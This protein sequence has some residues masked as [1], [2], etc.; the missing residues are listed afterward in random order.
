VIGD[1]RPDLAVLL[2]AAPAAPAAPVDGESAGEAA[3]A[4]ATFDPGPGPPGMGPPIFVLGAGSGERLRCL[5]AGRLAGVT[6]PVV[7]VEPC[8][9]RLRT[10]LDQPG[11][12]AVLDD[13]R[14][15][16]AV[17]GDLIGACGAAF[18][19]DP[20]FWF[21]NATFAAGDPAASRELAGGAAGGPWQRFIADVQQ[22]AR[23]TTA[24]LESMRAAFTDHRRRRPPLAALPP[25]TARI[26][27]VTDV[28]TSA[29][30][31]IYRDLFAAATGRGHEVTL[32]E[33]DYRSDPFRIHRRARAFLAAQPD[34]LVSLVQSRWQ[35]FGAL[36]DDVPAAV[37]YSSDPERY[38]LDAARFGPLDHVFVADPAWVA[39]LGRRGVRTAVL[40]L[41]TA[42][43]AASE[44]TPA[45][46]DACDAVMVCNLT[47]PESIAP[48][49]DAADVERLTALGI[50]LAAGGATSDALV[51]ASPLASREGPDRRLARA[52]E[53]AGTRHL[54]VQAA[55]RLAEA[56]LDLR[57]YGNDDWRAALAGTAASGAYRRSLDYRREVP[58]A[59]AGARVVVNVGSL[60][61]PEALNMR[62]FDAPAVGGCLVTDDRAQIGTVF[63]PGREIVVYRH[64]DELADIV[65]GL[66]DDPSRRDAIAEAGRAR[67]LRDHTYDRRWD[68]IIR[69]CTG[70]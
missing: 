24:D 27:G 18:D 64:L 41:A 8:P 4:A 67:V 33:E 63:A 13:R 40:P 30:Q 36:A 45:E 46:G 9:G 60:S 55:V 65:R 53:V 61:A 12:G 57:V 54:R 25:G 28:S 20:A 35:A 39:T 3:R 48:D 23:S 34:L 49:L 17:G 70:G 42:M 31:F 66:I 16:F 29:L 52:V 22:H 14:V 1:R 21:T 26:F 44:E 37:Y 50:T 51:Q 11:W 47:G 19:D 15:R 5:L 69:A 62:A 59:Y 38:G 7:I 56:G 68:E 58:A 2:A 10:S 6:R 32:V 43:R